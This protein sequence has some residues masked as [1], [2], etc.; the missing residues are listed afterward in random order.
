[1][2]CIL[3]SGLVA[4][5]LP[6]SGGGNSVSRIKI[7]KELYRKVFFFLLKI[8]R[9]KLSSAVLK[10][11]LNYWV[12]IFFLECFNRASTFINNINNFCDSGLRSHIGRRLAARPEDRLPRHDQSQW[13]RR[14]K[15]H[16]KSRIWR[17]VSKAISTGTG[18]SSFKFKLST[19]NHQ[20][21]IRQCK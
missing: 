15:R 13:G 8:K 2:T 5:R 1:M 7:P 21:L 20:K 6:A 14:R 19:K 16:K 17:R 9:S 3:G 4:Q 10:C 12:K 18:L 11:I